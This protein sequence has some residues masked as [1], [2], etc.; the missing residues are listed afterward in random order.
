VPP[1]SASSLP[2]NIRQLSPSPLS[3]PAYLVLSS[4]T[5][6]FPSRT[7]TYRSLPLSLARPQLSSY[8]HTLLSLLPSRNFRYPFFR[9]SDTLSAFSPNMSATFSELLNLFASE[10]HS[11][12]SCLLTIVFS[13]SRTLPAFCLSSGSSGHHLS[14]LSVVSLLCSHSSHGLPSHPPFPPALVPSPPVLYALYMCLP[15]PCCHRSHRYPVFLRLPSLSLHPESA[16]E[17]GVFMT[18]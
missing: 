15:P 12:T 9:L 14:T 6:P 11:C 2:S 13:H 18:A 1:C 10:G 17:A 4:A 7:F 16:P 5:L 8:P 3:F